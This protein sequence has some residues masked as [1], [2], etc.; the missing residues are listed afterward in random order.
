M[1]PLSGT[2]GYAGALF[3]AY[4]VRTLQAG[5]TIHLRSLSDTKSLV[6]LVP[7]LGAP[8]VVESNTVTTSNLPLVWFVFQMTTKVASWQSFY[9]QRQPTFRLL[10]TELGRYIP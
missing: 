5:G 1:A 3:E 10:T 9:G 8:V 7:K 2:E 4:A 6:L